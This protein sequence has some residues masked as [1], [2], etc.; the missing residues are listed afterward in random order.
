MLKKITIILLI[1][2]SILFVSNFA[3]AQASDLSSEMPE[4]IVLPLIGEI[5][6]GDFSLPVLSVMLGAIDGFNPCAMWVLLFLITMLLGMENRAR[7]WTLGLTFIVASA[8]VYFVF[9]MAWLNFFLFIGF[10]FWIRMAIG[11]VGIGVGAYHVK[12]FITNKDATCK[13]T[14]SERR[15]RIFERIKDITHSKNFW[16]ALGGIIILAFAVNLVEIFCS[17][18]IP[19]VFT[20]VLTLSNIPAWQYY[21][22]IL[23]YI[24]FFM[25][26]DIIVF[27]IAMVTLRA[28]GISTKYSRISNLV[29]GIILAIIGVILILKPE[30]LMFG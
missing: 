3:L 5:N 8:G 11:V 18:G 26:D 7:M 29:G 28:V 2:C 14:R 6:I 16:L 10:I 17:L 1:V 9:M 27:T 21:L 25:L 13:V 20:Q 30:W 24:F 22:Y 19:V 4:N 15:R 12:E 23:I